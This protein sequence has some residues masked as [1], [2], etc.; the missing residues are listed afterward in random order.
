MDEEEEPVAQED[1]EVGVIEMDGQ[2]VHFVRVMLLP[3][4]HDRFGHVR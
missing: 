1:T 4:N 2:A 3:P